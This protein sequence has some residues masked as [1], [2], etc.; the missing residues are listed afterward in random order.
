[1]RSAIRCLGYCLYVRS[2]L[3]P[4]GVYANFTRLTSENKAIAMPKHSE[5]LVQRLNRIEGQ[6]RGIRR[7]LEEDRYCIDVLNQ[8]L[9]V[10]AALGKV[11]EEVLKS[12]AASCVEDALMTGD[13]V[14]QRQKFTELVALFGKYN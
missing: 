14:E 9:A 10:Q 13:T 6:V 1:M 3:Y 11:Q 7:M 5:K 12:H 8:I 4:M 2:N